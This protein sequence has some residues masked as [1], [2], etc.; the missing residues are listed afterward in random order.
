MWTK[1]LEYVVLESDISS[2]D[3]QDVSM[4]SKFREGAEEEISGS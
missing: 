3:W 4:L 1:C 2:V